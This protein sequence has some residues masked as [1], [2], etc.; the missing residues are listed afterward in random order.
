MKPATHRHRWARLVVLVFLAA[1]IPFPA[2]AAEPARVLFDFSDPAA[3]RGWEVEDDVVMGGR[4]Q[5]TLA[6]DPAGWLVFRGEVSLDHNG[7]FSSVQCYF[8]PVGVSAYSHAVIRLKG[9]G[10][11]YRFMV[12]SEKDARHY[13]VTGFSTD[14]DWQEISIPLRKMYPM[15]RGDRLDIPDYPAETMSQVRFMI[16]NGRAESFQLEIASIKLE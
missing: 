5:G 8:D 2:P 3:M 11:D 16:A 15:R 7:G 13:Y 10:K 6:R 4:S 9:D 12:E 14:G 1:T